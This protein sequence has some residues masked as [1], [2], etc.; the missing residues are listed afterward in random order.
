M[1]SSHDLKSLCIVFQFLFVFNLWHFL[2][3]SANGNVIEKNIF[4]FISFCA[5]FKI[6]TDLFVWKR[7]LFLCGALYL[8]HFSVKSLIIFSTMTIRKFYQTS[9]NVVLLPS[10][11]TMVVLQRIFLFP[12]KWLYLET[13][14][15]CN[16]SSY[17]STQTKVRQ[18]CDFCE[19]CHR[20]K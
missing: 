2:T 1:T 7:E 19:V 18:S 8:C 14:L 12:S 3:V 15:P 4:I 17:K 20:N 13:L 9:H 6:E 10:A 5:A 16:A 11:R